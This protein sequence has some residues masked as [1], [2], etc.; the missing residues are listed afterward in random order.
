MSAGSRKAGSGK[1]GGGKEKQSWRDWRTRLTSH[2]SSRLTWRSAVI[3]ALALVVLAWALAPA[4]RGVTLVATSP[5]R[6]AP[7]DADAHAAGLAA[8]DVEFRATD[9]TRLAGWFIAS[10]P[11]APTVILVH[12]SRGSRTDMAP[13]ARF[14]VAAGYNVLL[15]DSRGCG[16]SD[17]W[18]ITLGAHEPDDILGA[19]TYLAGRADLT[20]KRF[21]A[22]GVSLGAGSVLLAAAREP[23][24][25]AVVAD[26]AWADEQPQLVRMGSIPIGRLGMPALPYEPA[27]VSALVG[28]ELRQVS[29]LAAVPA[30][31][32]RAVL[33]IHSADDANATT[34]LSGE[35]A[36]YGAA[37]QPKQE[38]IAASGGHVGALSAHPAEYQQHVLA[39]F[40]T[41]LGQPARAIGA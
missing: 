24:L 28:V 17:G 22:L 31:A 15:Y 37:G 18:H 7:S 16:A 1:A 34:P 26:S 33:L 21:G 10:S 20:A 13:W 19:V 23:K 4:V 38:W 8:Q 11:Q 27:L 41:Y 36:L 39:F 14:L 30:I 9:G 12:G 25:T 5:W 35:R 32:P 40:A 6:S 29:P 3:A 2:V